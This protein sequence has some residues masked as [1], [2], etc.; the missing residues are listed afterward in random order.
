MNEPSIF[1]TCFRI[2]CAVAALC[3]AA[4]SAAQDLPEF[5]RQVLDEE[6]QGG[7]GV[8]FAD[9]DGDG[10]TD[11]VAWATNPG[12]LAWFRNPDWDKY[13][14]T[15]TMQGNID[16][17]PLD[18]DGDGDVDLAL[19][20]DFSLGNSTGGGVIHWMENPGDPMANQEWRAHYIDEI[21]TSHR[22][23]WADVNG[24]GQ[25]EL[26]NLPIIGIGASGP[27]YDVGL[28][29]KSY[30][31]PEDLTV[32]SWNGVVLDDSLEMSHG[33]SSVDWDGD[34]R[35]DLLTASFGGVH[36]FQLATNG[37][38]V[39]KTRV[40]EVLQGP[41]RPGIG[42]SEVGV[43]SFPGGRYVATVEPWHGNQVVV[44]QG[45]EFP[46]NRIEIDDGLA[47]G[48]ALITA[49]LD[50]D[51]VDEI[52]AG[53]RSE[54]FLLAIYQYDDRAERWRR[55]DLDTGVAVSG[56]AAADMDGDGDI[57]LAAVGSATRSVV[58]YRNLGR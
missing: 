58:V 4:G 35:E 9:I 3:M 20:H 27:L 49:D 46:W 18:I 17:A 11:L 31:V 21:P 47:G 41:E 12:Q 43:G 2:G 24:D 55:Q 29:L 10:R 28:Q 19:A 36:L 34:G 15:S 42:S 13:A 50:N 56:L 22:V 14:V 39:S 44:Y 6:F 7:Y 8:D 26:V 48:H 16:S 23:R 53:G 54:P 25:Q 37:R 38:A 33:M 1:R 40:G 51:G 45:D 32:E 30:L 57:D 52:I 5:D